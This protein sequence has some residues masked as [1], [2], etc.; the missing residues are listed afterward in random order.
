[1]AVLARRE[2]RLQELCSELSDG[3]PL[4]CDLRSPDEIATPV[5][6]VLERHGRIDVLVNNAGTVDA[7]P[8]LEEP[9]Q[10]FSD[11]IAV[12]LTAQFAVAQAAARA[13]VD[14]GDGG[15]AGGGR[16]GTAA[17]F[18]VVAAVFL[19]VFLL[20]WRAVAAALDRR[21]VP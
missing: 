21:R 16:Q 12:N 18:V 10:T 6:T 11:V 1:M 14:R 19:G 20:G 2:E 8:A 13:M 5:E 15:A 4:P 17:A 9:L 7:E 3:L